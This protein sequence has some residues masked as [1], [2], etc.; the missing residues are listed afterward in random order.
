MT[1]A[2]PVT[3]TD[4]KA[5]VSCPA[6]GLAPLAS[7]TCTASYTITQ[8]NL[9]SGSVTNTAQAQANGTNSNTDAKTVTAFQIPR[10]TLVKTA[11]PTTYSAVGN[12]ISYSYLVTNNGNVTLAGPVTVTDD[13]ATVT[14]PAGGLAPLASKTCTASYT[15]TQANLDSGSVTNTAQAQANGTNSNTDDKTVIAVQSPRITLVKTAS[16]TTYSAVGNVISYSYLVTNIG[17]VTLA[18]PVTVTDD[19]ATVT[20][21]TGGLAPLAS[22]T[23]TASYTI[24]QA[25]LDSGS[26]TN[27]AQAQ[28]NG[29]NS[30][31]DRKTVTA[32]QSPRITL[33]KTASPTTYSAVGAVISY[34][35]LV[36]NIGNVTLAGPVTVTDDKATVTCP[37]GG[38]APLASKTCTASYTITQANL[39]SG[40]VTNTAQAQANG[41]NS[42]TDAKTVTGTQ[43]P[44]LSLT[45]TASPTTYSAVGNVISYSYLVTNNG[46]VTLA[47]P[48][49]VTDD[50][51]TVT[52]PAGGLAPLASKTCTASYTITQANLDSG[53]VTNTA[54]AHANGTNSNTAAK[55]VTAVQSPALSL[56]KTATPATYSAVNAVISYSYLVTNNGN[57]TLA[58]PVT[59]T[60]DKATVTCPAGGLAPLASKTCTASYTI[61]QANLDSGSVTN[62]AQA[63]ANGTNSN[64]AAK[65][66]TAVQSPALSLAKTASPATYSAVNAV[67]SYSYLVTNNGNVTLAGPVTVTDDKATVTC[68]AGGLAPLASKTCT[69]S[70]T[71]TQANLDSGSVTNTAQAH[72]N[73]TNSNTAVKTVTAVQSPA[74]SLV[75]TATPATYSAVNAVISYSYLVTN[76][77]NVTLAGPVTV[78]DDKAT[79]TCPAGGLAPLASKTCTA[80]YTITQA[81]LD[82]GS[83]TNTAQAHANGT[84]SNTDA[85]TV[86]ATRS[87]A[88][89][90]VKTADPLTYSAVNAVIGYSYLVT[91]IGNV[92]LAGPVTVTDDKATVTCPAGG[93]RRWRR[94]PAR[95]ATRS[96]RPTSTLAR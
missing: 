41:T 50:K 3:V 76:N 86:T 81:N 40:S 63:H 70:Y 83:V 94:R 73:G 58:G 35:Y 13:K 69:A 61:T 78:T 89:S 26:V 42:N 95:P 57:V 7:K 65:T 92:T 11:S 25:N 24:T 12:V 28:A 72:A 71:I 33:V 53:S 15:I 48:V 52:C 10:I 31:T 1:L 62:T 74:L 46:N 49:T 68:P 4:D 54:Q 23:C 36:T 43:T 59:V 5:T 90:L 93:S 56:V 79:V 82:S 51:A 19:K 16:P 34:S 64:T 87:P 27:T 67:I 77:G 18:G 45:K 91:N 84:N 30:N 14:C 17:N 20:C 32:V 88:L 38:L 66:V 85:K 6:D 39:D 44:L 9:D 47:G 37:A 2:G 96:R 80:S 29:T 60:D 55:T 21:P 75:K 8:A 22:K